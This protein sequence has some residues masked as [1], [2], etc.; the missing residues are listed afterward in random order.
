M[1]AGSIVCLALAAFGSGVSQ[2]L[3]DALL[4]QLGAEFSVTLGQAAQVT[5]LFAI[6]Y[7]LAQL[8][9][10]PLGD[11]YGKYR[12]VAWCS[13]ACAI[14]TLLCGLATDFTLLRLLRALSGITAAA[15]IPLAMAW[16]GDVVRYEER[17]PVLAR[18][19]IGQIL[20]VSA[21]VWMG[22]FAA[23]H[24]SWRAPYLLLAAL[25]AAI[26]FALFALNRRLPA[27]ARATRRGSGSA[28]GRIAS[29]FG[30]VLA[31]RW[32]RVV[33]VCVFLE[34]MLLYG[35]F[36]F[37]ASHL[38]DA[39][40]LSLSLAGTVVMLFGFGGFAFALGSQRLVAGLGE[41]GLAGWGGVVM[42]ASLLLVGHAPAWEWAV[43]GCFGAGLGFYMLHN[44]LQVNATQ[45]RPERRGA[46]VSA[47][48]SCFFLGQSAG[49]ATAALLVERLGT[50]P[51]IAAGALGLLVLA[52]AFARLRSHEL[53]GAAAAS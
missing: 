46:A 23:D 49:V 25:F 15:L 14:S 21:G 34:G 26:A 40:G 41:V 12:V 17:Q 35:P 48:A 19:L 16:I 5:S 50:A 51:V 27:Q 6:A 22:G 4:P 44:T 10:G 3:N 42:A 28:L 43:P 1:P 8:F 11:R 37:L 53:R 38:H 20:G 7:G 24:L 33:L 18:F 36:A 45:M 29:D 31:G 30:H 52:L 13:A 9:F 47:F 39:F 32:A 2:R